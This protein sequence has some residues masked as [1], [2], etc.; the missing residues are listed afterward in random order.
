[1]QERGLQQQVIKMADANMLE[2]AIH[3]CNLKYLQL[4]KFQLKEINRVVALL[5]E[6]G[7]E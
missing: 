2:N 7:I 5:K 3:Y 4:S 6:N 1:M